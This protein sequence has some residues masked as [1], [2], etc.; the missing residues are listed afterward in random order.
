MKEKEKAYDEAI[1][2]TKK[3][4]GNR[5][6]EEIFPELKESEDEK[7]K[8]AI[9]DLLKIWRNYKDYVCGVYVEDAIAWLEKQRDKDKL[10]Q[11]LGEYKVKYTQEVLEKYINSMSNKDDERLRKTAIAFLKDF[12]EQGYE[13]AVECIDWLEKKGEQNP[14]MIQWKG[15]NLKEVIDFTGKDKNFGKWFKSFEEY[16]KYVHEHNDIFKLFNENGNHYEIPVGAWIVKTPDGYNIAS[17]AVLKQKSAN[18]IE[19]RFKVGNWVVNKSDDPWHIDSFDNKNYQVS[20]RKGNYNYFPISKQD[21]MHLW[22]I[23]DAKDGDML[24]F[25]TEYR[26]NKMFQVGIIKKYVGK[27]GGCSNTFKMYVGVNWDN[28]LQIGKYMGCSLNIECSDIHPSTKEQRDF[29]FKKLKESGYKWNAGTKTLE[30]LE[31]SSFHEGDWVVRGDTIAQILDIQEQYYIGLDINGNVSS[32]FLNSDKIHLW[33]IQDAKDGDF[34][35]CKS[36]WMCIFKSLNN[37]TNTFSSYCFM[38]SDKCFFKNGGECHTLDKEFILAYNGE[39]HPA[40]KEQRDLLFQKIK[41]AGYKWNTETKTLE[42]LVEPKFKVGD[43][44]VDV[45]MKYMDTPGSQFIISEITEDKYIFTDSSYISISSQDSWELVPD[46]KPKFD[47][48]TLQP[49]DKV[50]VRRGNENYN[51]WFP[52]FVA[53][54]PKNDNNKTLCMCVGDDIAMV[55]PYNNDTKHLIGTTDEAPE[56]YRYWED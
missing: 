5:I 26:G 45:F 50:L 1:E 22:T 49:Y 34:L 27:R 21:E 16:E 20:D 10:I 39:I 33:T 7:I 8:N 25:Y 17:N 47:P 11:E 44:I 12:A 51:I 4:Y 24:S 6:A 13:N 54:P 48:K 23:Q 42:K 3:Y 28:N 30:K 38:D 52:D 41:E 29:L 56:Y 9:L 35:C 18:K 40:T 53:D 31:K 43:K 37:H 55:I 36:G 46:K 32:R 15:D 2:G 14:C 19:P